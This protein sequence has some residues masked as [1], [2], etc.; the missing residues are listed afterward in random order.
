ML[1]KPMMVLGNAGVTTKPTIINIYPSGKYM[2]EQG[3]TYMQA[4]LGRH[5]NSTGHIGFLESNSTTLI[6]QMA[7]FLYG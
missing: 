2:Q 6:E 3:E 7:G 4:H 5:F 1:G